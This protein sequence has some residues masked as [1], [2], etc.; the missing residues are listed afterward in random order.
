VKAKIFAA[1]LSVSSCALADATLARSVAIENAGFE[2]P[3]LTND[4]FT[5]RNRA[6]VG[7]EVYMP[8]AV[9]PDRGVWNPPADAYPSEAPEGR[10]VGW[11]WTGAASPGSGESGLTQTLVETLTPG[12]TYV[13]EVWV[14]D[15]LPYS[16]YQLSGFP[17]YRVELLAG[18]VVVAQTQRTQSPGEGTFERSLVE[19]NSP[20]KDDLAG[21]PL[22]IR[23]VHLLA[24]PGRDVDFDDVRLEVVPEPGAVDLAA[25]ALLMLGWLVRRRRGREWAYKLPAG[26][27]NFCAQPVQPDARVQPS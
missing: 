8:S 16:V 1:V 10:N 26:S 23:L 15:P 9:D 20:V 21:Q 5:N 4:S 12:A 25:A 18:G 19:Y 14:G 6:I 17:G 24:G 7:W 2:D 11:V 13:L 3:F 22:G 27:R